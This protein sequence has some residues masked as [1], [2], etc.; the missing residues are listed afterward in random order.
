MSPAK[1]GIERKSISDIMCIRWNCGKGRKTC[2][3]PSEVEI[4]RVSGRGR[5]A[6]CS[7]WLMDDAAGLLLSRSIGGY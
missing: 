2:G 7:A 4:G 1:S 3:D 6:R 5:F